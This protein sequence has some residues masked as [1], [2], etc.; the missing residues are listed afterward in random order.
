MWPSSE[1]LILLDFDDACTGPA[2]QD[3]WMLVHQ[4]NDFYLFLDTYQEFND[5]KVLGTFSIEK[6]NIFRLA[7]ILS[8]NAWLIDRKE[9]PYVKKYFPNLEN[10]NFW[11]S[12]INAWCS[13]AESLDGQ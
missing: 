6:R 1:K 5:P 3:V 10:S 11:E 12:E 7:R 8:Y 13:I 2:F 4:P 9:D